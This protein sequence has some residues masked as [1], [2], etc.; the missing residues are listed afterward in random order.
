MLTG[1][2][3]AAAALLATF[4]LLDIADGIVARSR[5]AD[6]THRRALDSA[7]DRCVVILCFACA[8][9]DAAAFFLPLA[10]FALA[11]I[12]VLPSAVALLRYNRQVVVAPS[13]HKS[14]SMLSAAAGLQHLAAGGDAGVVVASAAGVAAI[15]CSIQLVS[16]H[17]RLLARGAGNY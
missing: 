15:A 16:H 17:A 6:T 11:N 2:S 1:R 5:E 13:W 14:W 3:A 4:V 9:F 7:I 10:I 12:L 8:A